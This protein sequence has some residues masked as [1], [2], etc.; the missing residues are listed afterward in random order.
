MR[1]GAIGERGRRL[2]WWYVKEVHDIVNKRGGE[3]DELGE[4]LIFFFF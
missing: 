3:C 2:F 4:L 1:A